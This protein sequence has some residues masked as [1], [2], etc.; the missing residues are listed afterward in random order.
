MLIEVLL[1]FLVMLVMLLLLTTVSLS[2]AMTR[3]FSVGSAP[4]PVGT[5]SPHISRLLGCKQNTF[6]LYT[7]FRQNNTLVFL[8]WLVMPPQIKTRP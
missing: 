8:P 3:L 1:P 4:E 7:G 2:T 6:V 5:S